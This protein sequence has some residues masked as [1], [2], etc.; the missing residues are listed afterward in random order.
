MPVLK[1]CTSVKSESFSI[2]RALGETGPQADGS[3]RSTLVEPGQALKPDSQFCMR[4]VE[5]LSLSL[6][7]HFFFKFISFVCEFC[8]LTVLPQGEKKKQ[9]LITLISPW[10]MKGTTGVTIFYN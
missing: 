2:Q 8:A 1:N 3:S 10:S 6:Q 9:T 7:L 5:A 4:H